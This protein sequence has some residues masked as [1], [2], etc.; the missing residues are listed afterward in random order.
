MNKQ[1]SSDAINEQQDMPPTIYI[2]DDDDSLRDS[3]AGLFRSVGLQ[4]RPFRSAKD[5]LDELVWMSSVLKW[6]RANVPSKF[7]SK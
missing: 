5:F 1:K 3:L 6:G 4:A 7:H 2:V